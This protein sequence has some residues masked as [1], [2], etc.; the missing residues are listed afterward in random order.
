MFIALSTPQIL[1]IIIGTAVFYG[2]IV[3][4][5]Y[6][7]RYWAANKVV[8]AP[9]AIANPLSLIGGIAPPSAATPHLSSFVSPAQ[10]RLKDEGLTDDLPEE[11]SFPDEDLPFPEEQQVTLLKEAERVVEQIQHVVD[12]IASRPANPEE[13]FTKIQAIVSEYSFFFDTAYYDAINRFVAVTVHRDCDL[14]LT[15]EDLTTLWYAAAA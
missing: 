9:A 13:V 1:A 3:A 14:Q 7:R 2:L 5:A 4:F 11:P 12:N 15:E 8:S 6:G 10:S